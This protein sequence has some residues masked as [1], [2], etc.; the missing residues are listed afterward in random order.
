MIWLIP[1]A[2]VLGG[3]ALLGI[4]G[5]YI[6]RGSTVLAQRLGVP[7]VLTGAIIVG[8]GTS[9][10][11]LL[12]TVQASLQGKPDI[13]VGNVVGSN[14]ANFLF[15]L[16]FGLLFLP[17]ATGDKSLRQD[18]VAC[19]LASVLL[20]G[21]AYIGV[22][23][24]PV[25]GGMLALL[26][27]YLGFNCW[28]GWRAGRGDDADPVPDA[29][30]HVGF[31]LAMVAVAIVLLS[32]GAEL[33]INGAST[34]ALAL[35]IS[36]AVIGLSLVAVG[37]SLP[38]LAAV[39]ASVWQKQGSVIISSVL[40]S[41]LFNI[42]SILGITALIVPVPVAMTMA[43]A[44]IPLSLVVVVGMACLIFTRPRLTWHV[45]LVGLIGYIGYLL[46]LFSR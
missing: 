19:V 31:T 13:G 12:V 7:A 40:G 4:G 1:F 29:T 42:L 15:I 46:W 3:V 38:E 18:A 17:I 34:I 24:R 23:S 45:G 6:V 30:W 14:I 22:I 35:G 44:D 2:Q 36:Q 27:G 11:E 8:F 5:E 20:L 9:L 28:L 32:L 16:C 33:L 43:R 37:T 21:I 39:M 26:I 41:T 25:G 10:P